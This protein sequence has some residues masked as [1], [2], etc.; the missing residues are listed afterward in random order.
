MKATKTF[1]DKFGKLRRNGEEWLIKLSDAETY[2]PDVY[3]EVLSVL[4]I[5]TL[6]SRQFCVIL[7]PVGDSG[8]PQLGKKLLVKVQ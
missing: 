3:E 1:T 7:N 5:T 4:D 2:I 6:N 8:K